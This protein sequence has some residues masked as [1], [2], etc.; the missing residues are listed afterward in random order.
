[1]ASHSPATDRR[2]AWREPVWWLVVGLPLGVLVAG[3]LLIR[4]ALLAGPLD[5][6]PGVRR[7]GQVQMLEEA[8][9]RP[10]APVQAQ[11]P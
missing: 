8:P 2:S 4:T 9:Y 10:A 3:G 6:A 1:M 11:T 7:M 5:S